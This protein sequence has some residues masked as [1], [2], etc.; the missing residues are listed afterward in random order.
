LDE[1]HKSFASL[2]QQEQKYANIFIHDVQSGNLTIDPNKTFRDYITEYQF[3]AKD[4]EIHNLVQLLGL[5]ETKLRVMMG[6]GVNEANINEYG[7]FDDLKST[8][9][10]HKAKMYFERLS[11]ESTPTHRVNIKVHALLQKFIIEG[12][13]QI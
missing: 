1:L 10:K 9:D 11:G 8:L 3:T 4:A 6:A 12:G 2:T 5:D 7:R 13:F